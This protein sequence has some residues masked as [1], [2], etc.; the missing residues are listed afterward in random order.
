MHNLGLLRQ[1]YHPLQPAASKAAPFVKYEQRQPHPLLRPYIACYWQLKTVQPFTH[2]W[3]YHVVADGCTDIFFE[4]A[5]P[6]SAYIM[7]FC[8]QFTRFTLTYPFHY[9][10]IRFM[11][12]MFTAFYNISAQT[13]SHTAQPLEQ[14]LDS[15][16]HSFGQVLQNGSGFI[17][18]CN[19]LNQYLLAKSQHQPAGLDAR[20]AEA[21]YYILLNKGAL[22]L[23]T[24]V[25]T[26]LSPRQLRR[27]FQQYI[28]DSPKAFCKVVRFQALLHES[29]D[30]TTL[31][32]QKPYYNLGYYDQA[33]FIKDFTQ[34]YGLPPTLALP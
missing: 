31:R 20:F 34:L 24:Q 30:A 29:P 25:Q 13:I 21:L 14:I 11:P 1:L 6:H 7:G 19:R 5:K 15:S 3:P 18:T 27:Y 32:I 9:I 26:G 17:D 16:V 33:H 23:Q 4:A 10:G 8:N 28:G 22:N 12:A 2:A